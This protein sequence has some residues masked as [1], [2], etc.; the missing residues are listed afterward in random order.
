MAKNED[1]FLRNKAAHVAEDAYGRLYAKDQLWLDELP[2][3]AA[4]SAQSHTPVNAGTRFDYYSYH[5]GCELS[6][7]H[8]KTNKWSDRTVKH[9]AKLEAKWI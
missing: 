6:Y 5:L 7:F 4:V 1:K 3:G 9:R 2:A 8:V